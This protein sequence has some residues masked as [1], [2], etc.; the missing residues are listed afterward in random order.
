MT[1]EGDE[2][3][4]GDDLHA[5]SHPRS[6]A[7]IAGHPIHPMLVPFPI[8]G[9]VG[10]LVVDIIFL[11]NGNPGWATAS[12]WLLG[13]GILTGALA[14]VAGLTD[15]MGDSRIRGLSH[16]IQ[17]MIANVVVVV[18]EI[19]N[20]A[21]RLGNDDAISGTGVFL[22]VAAVVVLVFSGWRGGDLVYK[23]GIGVDEH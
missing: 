3:M 11:N 10:V 12:R 4:N 8:A 14:A 5:H 2:P 20:L 9:F 6:T 13:A 15:F 21:I 17:H 19:V 18:L 23:H 1:P 22:S 7:R 16:A